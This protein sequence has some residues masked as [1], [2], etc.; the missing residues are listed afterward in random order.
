[1]ASYKMTKFAKVRSTIMAFLCSMAAM[2]CCAP[3]RANPIHR[4]AKQLG[5]DNKGFGQVLIAIVVVAVAVIM[6]MVV[7]VVL[8]MFDTAVSN[9][10][11]LSEEANDTI[12]QVTNTG[13]GSLNLLT[14]V[15]YVLAAVA[16][17]GAVMGIFAYIKLRN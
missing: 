6:I 8:S 2:L 17:I 10:S 7:T 1:M 11:G 13:Y 5:K 16:I 15:L 14:I 12:A 9:I 3:V 4:F